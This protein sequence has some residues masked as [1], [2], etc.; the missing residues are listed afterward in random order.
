MIDLVSPGCAAKPRQ[1]DQVGPA[2]EVA[3]ARRLLALVAGIELAAHADRPAG[4]A[5]ARLERG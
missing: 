5:V 1:V 2:R 4:A 3:E